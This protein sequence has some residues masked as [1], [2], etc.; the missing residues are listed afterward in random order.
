MSTCEFRSLLP[1]NRQPLETALEQVLHSKYCVKRPEILVEAH[2]PDVCPPHL[3]PWLAYAESVDVWSDDWDEQTQRDVIRAS[4]PTHRMK[5]TRAAIKKALTTLGQSFSITEWWE[6]NAYHIPGFGHQNCTA[7]IAL[8]GQRWLESGVTLQDISTAV[9]MAKRLSLGLS[10][11]VDVNV[12]A[13]A[14]TA[15]A[16]MPILKE[17]VS[18][19]GIGRMSAPAKVGGF[20]ILK[21]SVSTAVIG[22]VSAPAKIGGFAVLREAA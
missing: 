21:D 5:G 8:D 7:W 19:T 13:T 18:A 12:S 10:T 9:G 17:A 22:Q 16:V 11:V 15:M 4:V 14:A 2:D 20:A 1:P 3:L 6:P